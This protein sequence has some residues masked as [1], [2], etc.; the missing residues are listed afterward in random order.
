[1]TRVLHPSPLC[2]QHSQSFQSQ[3][4]DFLPS[5]ISSVN[6]KHSLYT[7]KPGNVVN[8][9]AN[10]YSSLCTIPVSVAGKKHAKVLFFLSVTVY[11][12]QVLGEKLGERK[13]GQKKREGCKDACFSEI[14]HLTFYIIVFCESGS[15]CHNVS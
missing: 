8:N 1:M 13:D 15:I 9:T 11:F 6:K 7:V 5:H 12:R 10:L 3:T 2:L 4:T 14:I